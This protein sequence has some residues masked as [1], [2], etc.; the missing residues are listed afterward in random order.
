MSAP[1]L[2]TR[3]DAATPERRTAGPSRNIRLTG[4]VGH[5]GFDTLLEPHQ[6]ADIFAINEI[7][8]AISVERGNS[9]ID[10]DLAVDDNFEL[11]VLLEVLGHERQN[12]RMDILREADAQ[13]P[14]A[15]RVS[16]LPQSSNLCLGD[17]ALHDLQL[18]LPDDVNHGHAFGEGCGRGEEGG[19][20]HG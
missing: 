12:S 11:L 8:V 5:A 7:A 14:A 16:R 2:R 15:Y 13:R 3:Q 19:N 10:D 6:V 18:L 17:V 4:R 9:Q 20:Q 1:P